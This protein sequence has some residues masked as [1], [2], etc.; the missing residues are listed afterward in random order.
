[1]SESQQ[2]QRQWNLL[3][4]LE[5]ARHGCTLQQMVQLTDRSAKTVRR[6]LQTL[7]S[8]FQVESFTRNGHRIWKMPPLSEHLNFNLTELLAMH[9]SQQFLEALAGTVFWDGN[10]SVF[11][12][13]QNAIGEPAIRYLQKLSA[14]L[15]ATNVG[16]G[17]YRQRAALIDQLMVAIE[18]RQITI[19]VY[20]SMQ[21][22]E[23]VEQEVYP[24]GMVHHRGSLYLIAWSARR[25]EV[26]NF[27]VDR[28]N[29]ADVQN[30]Q[31]TVPSGFDLSDW[32]SKSFG[33]WR[34]GKEDLQT[35]RIHFTKDAARYIQESTWHK[36]QQLSL[37]EDGS[38]I[39][40]FQ[41]PDTQEI[42]RWI[43]SFGPSAKVLGPPEL[44]EQ[45]KEDLQRMVT[46]YS[47]HHQPLNNEIQQRTGINELR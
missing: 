24:L 2:L 20:Q 22:T 34:S 16:A 44:V 6:D 47:N 26:R 43:M 17:D 1:M 10:R 45:V 25:E 36:S 40:E 41:L 5:S 7:E 9:I 46:A 8:I 11:Q 18:D 33:I 35:I 32:L 29:E 21:A 23:P 31:Y 42:K 39:A 4:F 19:I 38:I 12:K 14:G 27:K 15:Q 3:R 37:R 28:I 30:L 13:V